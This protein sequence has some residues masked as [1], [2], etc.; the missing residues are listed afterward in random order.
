MYGGKGLND[1]ECGSI[2]EEDKLH[3]MS[4]AQQ[5][6]ALEQFSKVCELFCPLLVSVFLHGSSHT[7]RAAALTYMQSKHPLAILHATHP[8]LS[9]QPLGRRLL[10]ATTAAEEGL[11]VPSCELVRVCMYV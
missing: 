11:D 4:V 5:R 10:V 7:C 2:T 6:A 1:N 3:G 9:T 8:L